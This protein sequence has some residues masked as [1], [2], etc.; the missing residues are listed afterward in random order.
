[1]EDSSHPRGT[2]REGGGGQQ[3]EA[4]IM[5]LGTFS[6]R[7]GVA[8]P[9]E[10][11]SIPKGELGMWMYTAFKYISGHIPSLLPWSQQ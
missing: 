8:L 10:R 3:P 4:T 5:S 9:A 6:L 11:S 7:D 2:A 1:M